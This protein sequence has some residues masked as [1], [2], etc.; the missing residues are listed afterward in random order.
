MQQ[1]NCYPDILLC[2]SIGCEKAK[3]EFWKGIL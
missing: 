3:R 1:H 2:G